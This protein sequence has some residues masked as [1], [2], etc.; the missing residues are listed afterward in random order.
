MEENEVVTLEVD[1]SQAEKGIVK[2]TKDL[3]GLKKIADEIGTSFAKALDPLLTGLGNVETGIYAM[4]DSLISTSDALS[5]LIEQLPAEGVLG[6][7]FTTAEE[8]TGI[9]DLIGASFEGMLGAVAGA[10][11]TAII[12]LIESA[13]VALGRALSIGTGGAAALVAA[14]MAV[15]AAIVLLALNWDT[16]GSALVQGFTDFFSGAEEIWWSLRD[17]IFAPVMDFIGQ[18]CDDLW[19][20]HLKPLWDNICGAIAP[21]GESLLTIWETVIEPLINWIILVFAPAIITV[22]DAIMGAVSIVVGF[23]SD[24]IN[25]IVL[26]LDGFLQ[27]ITGAFSGD[28]KRAWEGVVKVFDGVISMIAGIIKGIINVIILALNVFIGAL[29][30]VIAGVV[31]AVGGIVQGFGYLIGKD[32]GF[33]VPTNPPQIPYLAKGAVLPANRPFLAVVGDQKHGTNI[34]APLA[35]IQEAV[36][37]VM[38]AHIAAMMS[39]FQA[40]IAEQQAT[41][42]AVENIRVGDSVIGEAAA[43]YNRRMAIA[44]GTY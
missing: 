24:V 11:T 32:W 43:R 6:G 34:E 17:N 20:N 21:I 44:M 30:S 16:Y 8:M 27:F 40:L 3:T 14:I 36:A 4:R 18:T 12:P 10:V 22:I 35:T 5:A 33:S 41:R 15:I 2:V 39:G 25:A 9:N 42:N 37:L 13:I 23:I 1:I 26:A 31:N 19:N 7:V 29:Y 28:W 38:D